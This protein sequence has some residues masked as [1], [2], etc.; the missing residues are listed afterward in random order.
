[1]VLT[2]TYTQIQ[3]AF[4]NPDIN[5]IIVQGGTSSSKTYSTM[6]LLYLLAIT[7]KKKELISVVS[8]SLPHLKR[9]VIRDLQSILIGAERWS[10]NDFNKSESIYNAKYKQIEFFGAD[11]GAKLHGGRRDYLF[12]NEANHI[13]ET[14]FT[15]LSIRT[16]KKTIIDYNPTN[17]FWAN[18][19]IGKKGVAF[20]KVTYSDN[21]QLEQGI[22]DKIESR[23]Y[24]KEGNITDWYKVY[25]L[26][27]L[28][29]LEGTVY[30]N[31]EQVSKMPVQ[32]KKEMGFIDFGFTND[33]TAIGRA[34]LSDNELYVEEL[35]YSTGLTNQ[36]IAKIII[37]NDLKHLTFICDGA[38]PKSVKELQQAGIKCYGVVKPKGSINY[39]IDLLEHKGFKIVN[40][41]LNAIQELRSYTWKVDRLTGKPSNIPIDNFNHFLD[42]FRYYALEMLQVKAKPKATPITTRISRK[43]IY[44]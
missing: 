22:I 11:S 34:G 44:R 39:G 13:T 12:I 43:D 30:K 36:D 32:L 7:N 42:G 8:E 40:T 37:K 26:G 23:K 18:D 2:D 25:G 31:W 6:Q 19:L 29:S 21:N 27:E 9:G 17:E 33:P 14:A 24:D 28:G 35:F 41:S 5:T 15:Q 3:S 20:I 16:R 4:I 1:M 10:D 38:E